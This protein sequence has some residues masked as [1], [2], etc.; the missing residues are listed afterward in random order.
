MHTSIVAE[1]IL[2][3]AVSALDVSMVSG[4]GRI[5]LCGTLDKSHV[6]RPDETITAVANFR[7]TAEIDARRCEDIARLLSRTLKSC[8]FQL[9]IR[10]VGLLSPL[11]D[12]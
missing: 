8:Q 11:R 3:P 12:S 4:H 5:R 2:T 9:V 1:T 10:E 6:V 7:A